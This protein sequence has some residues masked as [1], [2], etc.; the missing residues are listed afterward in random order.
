MA[1]V[2]HPKAEINAKIVYFGPVLAGKTTN[3]KHVYSKLKPDFRGV[4]KT[5]NVQNQK[6]IF[7]DFTP[8]GEGTVHGYRARFHLYTLAGNEADSS[9]W[10]MLL[11]G[12]DGIVFVADSAPERM[13]ANLESLQNLDLFL[14]SYGRSLAQVPCIIQFNKRDLPNALS[15]EEMQRIVSA[16]NLPQIAAMA[17]SGEGVLTTLLSL[18]KMVYGELRNKG[19]DL[20][21]RSEQLQDAKEFQEEERNETG[22][23][24]AVE[25]PPRYA[26]EDIAEEI[27]AEEPVEAPLQTAAAP[28]PPYAA[29]LAGVPE[30]DAAGHVSVPLKVNIGGEEKVVTVNLTITLDAGQ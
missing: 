11:K 22:F 5:M 29:A 13:A 7:F 8:P 9:T 2:N 28:L 27:A 30:F 26:E 20:D 10:K 25:E 14:Q 23:M 15:Q 16:G 3:L 21:S 17:K 1:L 19:L 12:V 24:V 6:M 18:V 4:L